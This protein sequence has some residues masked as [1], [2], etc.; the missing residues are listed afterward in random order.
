MAILLDTQVL[1]W[2]ESHPLLIP[3]K[4][5]DIIFKTKDIYF[6]DVSVW[7]MAIKIKT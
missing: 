4:T 5:R 7:E 2:L 1:I 6:S 3:I